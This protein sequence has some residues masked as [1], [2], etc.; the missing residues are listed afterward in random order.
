MKKNDLLWPLMGLL[1]FIGQSC[2][3]QNAASSS[4]NKLPQAAALTAKIDSTV[5]EAPPV[6][7]MDSSISLDYLMGKFEPSSHPDFILIDK[8]YASRNGM[9]LRKDAY[10]AF[11]KMHA[12]AQK[13][14]IQLT[15]RSATR[16]FN[17]QKAIWEG[18]W[19][20][21]RRLQGNEDASK[22]Y[23]DPKARALKILEWS[24]MPGSSRHHW[25]S[26]IDLN[27]FN[28]EYFS[29]GKGLKEYEWLVAHAAAYGYCQPYSPK[30]EGGRPHGYNEERWHWSYLPFALRCSQ[31]AQLRLTNDLVQGF[32]GAEVAAEV[33]IVEKYV[34]GINPACL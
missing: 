8:A 12:A 23:P 24:S 5:E 14:G 25:G 29:K 33:E 11:K 27:A 31:Q 1:F 19:T 4:D 2:T 3:Q 32:K 20:G 7:E 26:D 10:E 34:L 9:Y 21:Q 16:N 6:I 15:I 17:A 22:R 30:G 13:A 18:K 28:N